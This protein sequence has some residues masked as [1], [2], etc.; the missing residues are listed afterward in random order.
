MFG[1]HLSV[2]GGLHHALVEA[3]RLGMDCVQVFTKNQRQWNSPPLPAEAVNQWKQHQRRTGITEVVS[4]DSYLIN[5]ASPKRDVREKSIRLFMDEL[6]RCE[7]LDIAW[8]VAHPG[9]HLGVGEAKGLRRVAG[10]LDRVHKR[11]AGYRTVTC[12]EITAGQGS[13]LGYRFEHLRRIIDM[14]AEPDRL[15]VCFDTAH[16]LEAGYDLTSAPGMRRTLGEFDAVLGLERLK[17][18]HIND[19]KTPRGS[20]VD[21][22]AHIGHGHVAKTAFRA[23]VN[24]PKLK[25]IPKILETP[26]ADAPEGRPWDAVNLESLRRMVRRR[27]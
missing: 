11:L 25:R 16:A 15:A 3:K 13:G 2:A 1:S 12:L 6:E 9:A 8:L 17:V 7:V 21:R 24:H 18:V 27:R 23:L 19:S 26:K 22:H 5:L 20:R 4:H 14:T 10:A